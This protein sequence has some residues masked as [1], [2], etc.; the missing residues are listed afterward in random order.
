MAA[1][2]GSVAISTYQAGRV[3]MVGFGPRGND[4]TGRRP[5]GKI[6][7]F[8]PAVAMDADGD[9]VLTWSQ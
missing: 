4:P 5:P 8:T 7:I 3:V 2:G 6:G 9:F 1:A